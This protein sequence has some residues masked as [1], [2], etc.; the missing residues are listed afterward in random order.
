MNRLLV[1]CGLLA[2]AVC[3]LAT[4][5]ADAYVYYSNNS[6]GVTTIGRADLEGGGAN[7]LF[8]QTAPASRGVAVDARHLYWVSGTYGS[9]ARS[10]L[11]GSQPSPLFISGANVPYAVAVDSQHIYWTNQGSGTIGRANL[12]GSGVNQNFITGAGSPQGIAVDGEHIYWANDAA[13]TI[14]RANLDGSG[15]NQRWIQGI[16]GARGLAVDGQYVWW[17]WP[18]A[19]GIG[20]AKLDGTHTR[21][22]IDTANRAEFVAVD[23]GHVY[24]TNPGDD[25]IG[26]ANLDGTAPDQRFINEAFGPFGIAVDPLPLGTARPS[27]A[28]LDFGTQARDTLGAARPLTVRN[29]GPGP[30]HVRRVAVTGAQHDDFLISSDDCSQ[31]TLPVGGSCTVDLRFGPS[32]TGARAATL[33]VP[34]D[35][36]AGSLGVPL[37]GVGGALPAGPTG[38]AGPAGTPG[39]PGPAGPAGTPGALGP[40]GTPGMQGPAGGQGPAGAPGADG[41]PGPA[42]APGAQGPAGPQGERG[43]DAAVTC[44]LKRRGRARVICTV[45]LATVAGKIHWRLVKNGHVYRRGTARASRHSATIRLPH[46]ARG[47]YALRIAGRR[48]GATIVVGS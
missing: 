6:G 3:L 14:V 27:A 13:N 4:S 45:K 1:I 19:L 46:L 36:P 5:Q 38:P 30:L 33:T 15:V 17:A 48:G 34:S 32:A 18:G 8:I 41:S 7:L 47:R 2:T 24:W 26:R 42:G 31:A 44:K 35:D 21:A 10:N 37:T 16:L 28:S 25:G 29:D 11:D 39:T 23:A 20:R 40:A 22:L 9:I 12:D 43:R